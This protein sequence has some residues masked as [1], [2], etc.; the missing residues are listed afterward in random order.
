MT[1]TTPEALVAATLVLVADHQDLL[2]APAQ[3]EAQARQLREVAELVRDQDP[4]VRGATAVAVFLRL[5]DCVGRLERA[6]QDVPGLGIVSARLGVW[7]D[8]V[9]WARDAALTASIRKGPT[10]KREVKL[11]GW[12]RPG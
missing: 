5:L 11:K 12:N 6:A 4:P 1:P 7:L 2:T 9:T 8:A 10:V 3:R